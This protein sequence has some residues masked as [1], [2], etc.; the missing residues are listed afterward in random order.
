MR[1]DQLEAATLNKFLEGWWACSDG[2]Y[3]W[4]F[5][6]G[7]GVHCSYKDHKQ[8]VHL[9]GPVKVGDDRKSFECAGR[10]FKIVDADTVGKLDSNGTMSRIKPKD[11][12]ASTKEPKDTFKT[13]KDP[14]GTPAAGK[15]R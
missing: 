11:D 1:F 10:R 8:R 13:P 2:K 12:K 14:S 5:K 6:D 3:F 9:E 15:R 7:H 4:Q